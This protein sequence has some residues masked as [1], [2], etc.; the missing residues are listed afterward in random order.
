M[1]RRFSICALAAVGLLAANAIAQAA[2]TLESIESLSVS[3]QPADGKVLAIVFWNTRDSGMDAQ[4][5]A[6]VVLYRRFHGK[7]LDMVGICNDASV[8]RVTDFAERWQFPWPQ[9]MDAWSKENKPFDRFKIEKTPAGLLLAGKD[10]PVALKLDKVDETHAAVAKALGVKLA[11]LPMPEAPSRFTDS[12]ARPTDVMGEL[13]MAVTT[14][15]GE[16]AVSEAVVKVLDEDDSRARVDEVVDLLC[17]S[18]RKGYGPVIQQSIEKVSPEAKIRMVRAVMVK[19]GDG[20]ECLIPA[21]G[22]IG[23]D[24]ELLAK[25]T[26]WDR[27]QYGRALVLAGEYEKGAAVLR[28]VAEESEG[29]T[30]WWYMAGWAE[31]C[32]GKAKS[33]AEALAKSYKADG[34]YSGGAAKIGGNMAGYFLGKID[35]A[36]MFKAL[37]A[38]VAQFFVAE[39]YMLVGEKDKA[40]EAYNACI[41]A[42]KKAAD[43]WPA[44]WA[45]LRL[46]QLEGQAPGL[47]KPLP[48][49][50]QP[51]A[52]K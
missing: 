2:D 42:A 22:K 10:E 32:G 24:D 30:A 20:L 43:P 51:W 33:A 31:L 27:S 37:D 52:N 11:D 40:A 41:K 48:A 23:T 5:K 29:E 28:K 25:V 13:R 15:S 46:K 45:K 19:A 6:A 7:G 3:L 34:E 4:A 14:D 49:D 18:M 47:P 8:D 26:K 35:E 50:A 21:V 1:T 36:A 44:N 9:V 12:G 17:E 38:R 39:R 16:E